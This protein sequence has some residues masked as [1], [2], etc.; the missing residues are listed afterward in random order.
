MLNFLRVELRKIC[1]FFV[2]FLWHCPIWAWS[3]L[4]IMLNFGSNLSLIMLISVM[5][6]KK[7]AWTP[8][9]SVGFA[10][11]TPPF[12]SSK[13]LF[14][15]SSSLVISYLIGIH[16][17]KTADKTM[18]KTTKKTRTKPQRKPQRKPWRKLRRKPRRKLRRKP[19]KNCGQNCGQ[20]RK[21]TADK[22]AGN[23]AYKSR[24]AHGNIVQFQLIYINSISISIIYNRRYHN[25][26]KNQW[27]ES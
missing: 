27:L 16:R 6:I 18:D 26:G 4:Q 10:S 22:T 25:R 7:L 3:M 11:C 21:Q 15:K 2:L 1:L 23:T 9:G 5:L 17:F 19:R 12:S 24:K 8:S 13:P 20:N 14:W